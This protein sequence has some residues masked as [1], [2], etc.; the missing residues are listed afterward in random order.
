MWQRIPNS[1]KTP[2]HMASIKYVISSLFLPSSPIMKLFSQVG[3]AKLVMH[4]R[5]VKGLLTEYFRPFSQ[6]SERQ[7]LPFKEEWMA[8]HRLE[9]YW[10]AQNIL[11][12]QWRSWGSGI[13]HRF[14]F[15]VVFF[16]FLSIKRKKNNTYNSYRKYSSNRDIYTIKISSPYL[17]YFLMRI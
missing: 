7:S 4:L 8:C 1:Y 5:L 9:I 15:C 6:H 11:L 14:Y 10:T 17:M 2:S 13:K 12:F 3:F 16:I